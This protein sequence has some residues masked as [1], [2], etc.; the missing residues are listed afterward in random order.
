MSMLVAVDR[1]PTG[2]ERAAT[3]AVGVVVSVE[4]ASQPWNEYV[5]ARTD[6]TG[7]HEESGPLTIL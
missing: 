5:A 3:P 2:P 6:A 1:E 7:Y 4:S